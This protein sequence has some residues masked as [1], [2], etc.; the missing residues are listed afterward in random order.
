MLAKQVLNPI[1]ESESLTRGLADPEA[2]ILIEWL[3]AQAERLADYYLCPNL[4]EQAVAKL[5]RRMRILSRFVFLWQNP[6]S[7][8]AACQLAA[9][10]CVSWPLPST[11]VDPYELLL[12]LLDY[13]TPTDLEM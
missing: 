6:L 11:D 4:A 1:F 5:C 8:G 7:R 13:E 10:E 9:T 2:R 3:V 12:D